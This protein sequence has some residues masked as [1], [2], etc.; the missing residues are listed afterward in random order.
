LTIA[1]P[2]AASPTVTTALA[3]AEQGQAVGDA[4]DACLAYATCQWTYSGVA[5]GLP[6]LAPV[7]VVGSIDG[8]LF[9]DSYEL[10]FPNASGVFRFYQRGTRRLLLEKT[11]SGQY[12]VTRPIGS[13]FQHTF[14]G[15]FTVTRVAAP[16]TGSG[17]GTIVLHDNLDAQTFDAV[18]EG[19]LQLSSP[20]R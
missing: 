1:G 14:T 19:T 16:Y 13:H 10:C 12:C 3:L 18:E 8:G 15:T 7:D 20:P 5:T 6:F 11:V 2:A 17:T 4:T 9:F